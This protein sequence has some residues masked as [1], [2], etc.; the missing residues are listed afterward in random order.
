MIGRK[1]LVI[2]QIRAEN[3]E[4]VEFWF[5]VEVALATATTATATATAAVP[6]VEEQAQL[7]AV[8]FSPIRVQVIQ[9]LGERSV[10]V[11][12]PAGVWVG[13]LLGWHA[14]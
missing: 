3:E 1:D 10:A 9:D 4:A 6:P 11:G 12:P 7:S 13:V 8:R 2:D 5:D 14:F